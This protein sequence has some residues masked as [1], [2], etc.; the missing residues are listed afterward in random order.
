MGTGQGHRDH[1]VFER[2]GR[3]IDGVVLEIELVQAELRAEIVG[4][5]ER[6]EAGVESRRGLALDG[7]KV[8]VA[9][10]ALRP[11]LNRLA[12]EGCLDR[13]VVV[14]N[15]QGTEAHIADMEGDSGVFLSAL[16]ADQ[17]F[18]LVYGLCRWHRR[19]HAVFTAQ[20]SGS[21]SKSLVIS[22]WFPHNGHC[23]FL[24]ILISRKRV[25]RAS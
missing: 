6:R 4:P 15:F 19:A 20:T 12:G 1:A 24:A 3:V 18:D 17:P 23:R 13:L 11:R 2:Q 9:P 14:L 10:E 22:G 21:C 7:E 5:H 8:Y 25:R 16:P